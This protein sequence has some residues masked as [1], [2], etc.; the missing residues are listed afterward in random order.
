MDESSE[1][2]GKKIR[3]GKAAKVPYL[4]VVGAREAQERSITVEGHF[5]GRLDNVESIQALADQMLNEVH[6]EA[7]RRRQIWGGFAAENQ[8]CRF[9]STRRFVNTLGYPISPDTDLPLL[10]FAGQASNTITRHRSSPE[11]RWLSRSAK[12]C[13]H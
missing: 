7:A 12:P 1:D 5:N 10:E 8:R 11:R 4:I 13:L 2:L 9:L 3:S 6:R